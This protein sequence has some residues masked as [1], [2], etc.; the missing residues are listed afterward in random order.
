M[1]AIGNDI[2]CTS[3][4]TAAVFFAKMEV[5]MQWQGGGCGAE[6]NDNGGGDGVEL[7]V[8]RAGVGRR[9]ESGQG[10]VD[11]VTRAAATLLRVGRV[12]DDMTRGGGG[13]CEVLLLVQR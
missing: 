13:Q 9:N 5:V 1:A 8:M 11:A 10:G 4:S 3:R 12:V 2:P 6:G 7:A